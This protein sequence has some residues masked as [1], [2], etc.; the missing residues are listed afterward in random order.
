MPYLEKIPGAIQPYYQPYMDAGTKA[1]GTLQDQYDMLLNDPT[2]M[3]NKIGA[4]YTASPGYQY[5]VDQATNAANNSAAAGGY[6]GSPAEQENLAKQISGIASQ[7]YNTYMNQA[8]GQY[9]IG[10]QG[11]QGLNQM[12]YNAN[13]GYANELADVYNSEANLSYAGTQ[14]ENANNAAKWNNILKLGGLGVGYALGGPTGAAVAGSAL[15]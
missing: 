15:K 6:V 1:L 14:G 12:G 5:N 13:T 2:I 9:G 11:T 8:L 3:M 7:D 10:L 4:S